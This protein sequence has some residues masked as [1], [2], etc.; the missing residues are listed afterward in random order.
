MLID[1]IYNLIISQNTDIQRIIE[2]NRI[3]LN[4]DLYT[5]DRRHF[6]HVMIIILKCIRGLRTV[7]K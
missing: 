1:Y 2:N 3:H 4:G 5:R 7:Y 6:H